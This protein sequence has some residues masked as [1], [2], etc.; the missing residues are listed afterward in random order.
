M[1]IGRAKAGRTSGSPGEIDDVSLLALKAALEIED[2]RNKGSATG[3]AN[4]RQPN[5]RN[6]EKPCAKHTVE[7]PKR[8]H[9]PFPTTLIS[10]PM[11]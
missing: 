3:Y 9:R 2:V 8:Q 11:S 4:L 7:L 5:Q 1:A 6:R 10:Y